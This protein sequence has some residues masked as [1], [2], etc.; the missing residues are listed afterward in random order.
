MSLPSLHH[1][2]FALF[3]AVAMLN[4]PAAYLDASL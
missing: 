2:A 3:V 4:Q 1:T